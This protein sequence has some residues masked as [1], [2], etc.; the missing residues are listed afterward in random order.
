MEVSEELK[1]LYK[2]LKSI[3]ESNGAEYHYL[4]FLVMNTETNHLYLLLK[5]LEKMKIKG[6]SLDD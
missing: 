1:Q 4:K 3:N 5:Q 6:Y 2:L